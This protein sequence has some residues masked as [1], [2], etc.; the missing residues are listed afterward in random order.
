MYLSSEHPQIEYKKTWFENILIF[1]EHSVHPQIEYI[2]TWFSQYI[3]Y[4]LKLSI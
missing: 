1:S 2:K 4:I 3:Q